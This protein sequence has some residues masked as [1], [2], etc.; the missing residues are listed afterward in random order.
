[1]RG[2][3]ITF[4]GGDGAGKT[5]QISLARSYLESCGL[6]LIVTR[7]PGG[8]ELAEEI[9][10][11]VLNRPTGMTPITEALLI[12]AARAQHTAEVILPALQRGA[13]VL[14]DRYTDASFAYQGGGRGLGDGVIGELEKIATNSLQ[15]DLTL[16]LDLEVEEGI[17][18]SG[19]RGEAVDRFESEN[20]LFKRRIR[21]SYLQRQSQCSERIKLIDGALT[22]DAVHSRIVEELDSLREESHG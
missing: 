2:K 7:E 19:A 21:E 18:R 11:L 3:F 20:L 15:P 12:F 14:C 16:L 10:D 22:A 13:W 8:T 1:M 6:A 9:R 17:L 4:E 5:T